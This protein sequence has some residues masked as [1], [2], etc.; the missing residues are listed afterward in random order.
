MT[1]QIWDEHRDHGQAR[2]GSLRRRWAP[3]VQVEHAVWPR[4]TM[5]GLGLLLSLGGVWGLHGQG[6][7]AS[8]T[9]MRV[10]TQ[11]Q[12]LTHLKA[13]AIGTLSWCAAVLV[14]ATCFLGLMLLA[15]WVQ[16]RY[17][18]RRSAA[19]MERAWTPSIART[20]Q[21]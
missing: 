18:R 7:R 19:A 3:R 1:W 20:P 5:T 12:L 9:A 6:G 17:S 15:V 14:V 21:A 4:A 11:A 16:Q 10:W 13:V 8:S 2:A